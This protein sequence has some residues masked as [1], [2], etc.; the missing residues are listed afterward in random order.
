MKG[1]ASYFTLFPVTEHADNVTSR[2]PNDDKASDQDAILQP[3]VV[4][5]KAGVLNKEVLA[6][7]IEGMEVVNHLAIGL[8][9][10]FEGDL[11][12]GWV[13]EVEHE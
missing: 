9:E 4:V 10:H 1:N 3:L 2:H 12:V 6:F 13:V 11:L 7:L 8:V 5:A